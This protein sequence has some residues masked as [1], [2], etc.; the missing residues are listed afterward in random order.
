MNVIDEEEKKVPFVAGRESDVAVNDPLHRLL[1]SN[2]M[3][4]KNIVASLNGLVSSFL[5]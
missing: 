1:S 2:S 4:V 3:L 5:Y